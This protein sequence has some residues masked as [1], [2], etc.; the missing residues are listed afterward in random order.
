MSRRAR[1]RQAQEQELERIYFGQDWREDRDSD[2]VEIP[3][4]EDEPLPIHT[5]H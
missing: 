5:T 1:Q 3:E 2:E 4:R